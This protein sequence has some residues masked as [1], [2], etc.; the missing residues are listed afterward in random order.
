MTMRAAG[1][2]TAQTIQK[3]CGVPPKDV[4]TRGIISPRTPSVE[5]SMLHRRAVM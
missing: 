4:K 5:L 3:V 2:Q 1:T